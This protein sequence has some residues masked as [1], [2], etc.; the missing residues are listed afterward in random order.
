[1][2]EFSVIILEPSSK[3]NLGGGAL[4]MLSS[5]FGLDL[6]FSGGAEE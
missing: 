6:G 1:M 2:E 5:A 4:L 3:C